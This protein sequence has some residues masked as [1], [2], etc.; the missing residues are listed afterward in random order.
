LPP[1]TDA[2]MIEHILLKLPLDMSMMWWLRQVNHVWHKFVDE[3]LEWHALN[4]VKHHNVFYHHT[5]ATQGLPRCFLKQ[6]LQFE[7]HYLNLC[8]LDDTKIWDFGFFKASLKLLVFLD[9]FT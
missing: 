1:L 7:I 3:S 9:L 6:H 8:F 5:I 4:I 2:F